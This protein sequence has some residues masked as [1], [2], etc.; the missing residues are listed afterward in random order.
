MAGQSLVWS[1]EALE[2][3]EAIAAYIARDSA[4]YAAAVVERLL[5]TAA[6]LPSFPEAGRVVP[7]LGEYSIRERFVYSYRLIYCLQ[8]GEILVVAVIHGRRL[9]E[10]A[11][12]GR[13]PGTEEHS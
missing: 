7:E 1:P 2:D 8:P 5:A 10:S 12:E 11:I 13:L 3:V 4:F 6:E 9:L